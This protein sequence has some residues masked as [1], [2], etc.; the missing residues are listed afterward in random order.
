MDPDPTVTRWLHVDGQTADT[1]H[2]Y[3]LS[4]TWL[5][6]F[7]FE[8]GSHTL[9]GLKRSMKTKLAS[10]SVTYPRL[11]SAPPRLARQLLKSNHRNIKRPPLRHSHLPEV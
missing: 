4:S 5:L 8:T 7:W 1:A 10:N 11:L 6:L 2:S 9:T 3:I